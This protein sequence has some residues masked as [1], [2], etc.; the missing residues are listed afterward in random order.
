MAPDGGVVMSAGNR[1]G[2][3]CE[4]STVFW[5]MKD[6][7]GKELGIDDMLGYMDWWEDA[8]TFGDW[9]RDGYV[10][11]AV[12]GGVELGPILFYAEDMPR[13]SEDLTEEECG[14]EVEAVLEDMTG[15]GLR[16]ILVHTKCNEDGPVDRTWW[17]L[18]GGSF[19]TGD[20]YSVVD[21]GVRIGM[22]EGSDFLVGPIT[23]GNTTSGDM[24]GD[25]KAELINGRS[26]AN[27]FGGEVYI[28][29]GADLFPD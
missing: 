18:E 19:H 23:W 12:N 13:M 16:E 29:R 20:D 4:Y 27:D 24:D 17:V 14:L 10:D 5:D 9:N 11:M 25:G 21:S 6:A 28:W 2:K 1:N 7:K 22:S 15:D 26:A 8:E 3:F